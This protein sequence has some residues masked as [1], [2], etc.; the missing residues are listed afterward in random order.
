MVRPHACR[1][2]SSDAFERRALAIEAIEHD[3][4]RQL[5]L[6]GRGPGLFGLHF[7]AGDGVDD[8]EG[9][10]GDAHRRARVA[11][12]IAEAGRIDEVDFGLVPLGVGEAGGQRV[13]A[14]D[15]F[16]VVVGDR[17]AVVHLAEPVHHPGGEEQSRD[18]LGLAASAVADHGHI[19]DAGGVV[20]LHSGI[21]PR[22]KKCRSTGA[23]CHGRR[24]GAAQR[25]EVR[26]RA[27]V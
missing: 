25:S 10:V 18:Q 3:D 19:P 23:S 14:G 21:P 26:A 6:L 24:Y 2:D 13:F 9:G 11:E 20:D 16:V 15:L 22:G 7:D 8:E 4:A 17:V 5:E 1:S 27:A 12:E